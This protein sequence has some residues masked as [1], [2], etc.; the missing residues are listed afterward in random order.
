MT[1]SNETDL[2]ALAQKEIE[3]RE[4]RNTRDRLAREFLK[5]H[6]E[7]KENPDCE[8]T[9]PIPEGTSEA[10]VRATARHYKQAKQVRQVLRER[11]NAEEA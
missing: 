5:E 6:P 9:D 3:R 8:I 2:E 1:T 7:V 10:A 4:R 11:R